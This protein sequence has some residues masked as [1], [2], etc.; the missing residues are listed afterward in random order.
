M[1]SVGRTLELDLPLDYVLHCSRGLMRVS[2]RD[3]NFLVALVWFEWF[4]I[5]LS[6]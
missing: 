5:S 2:R 3:S 6:G 1:K 4:V